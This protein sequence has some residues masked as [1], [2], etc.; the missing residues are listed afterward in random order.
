MSTNFETRLHSAIGTYPDFPKPGIEFRDIMPILRD[1]ALLREV[2]DAL[3][4]EYDIDNIDAVAGPESRGF[5]FGI[6]LAQKFDVP[7][8]AIR[9]PGKL[10]G[11][12]E[13][14]TYELEYGRDEVQ[15]QRGAISPGDHVVIVDD[16]L[17]TGGTA[18]ASAELIEHMGGIVEGMSFVIELPLLEGRKKLGARAVH[19][20]MSY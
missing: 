16:L 10:P 6:L 14:Q 8:V 19:S 4:E 9:K 18:E 15:I 7:F 13:S 20:L 5:L 12:V 1:P 2:I 17:A 3:S 11:E